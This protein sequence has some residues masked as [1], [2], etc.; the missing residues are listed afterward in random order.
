MNARMDKLHDNEQGNYRPVR[1]RRPQPDDNWPYGRYPDEGDDPQYGIKSPKFHRHLFIRRDQVFFDLDS[2]IGM[3]AMS[4]RKEDGTEDD[5]L[6]NATTTYRQ[7]FCR[8]M[9]KYLGSAKSVM[10]AFVLEKFKTTDMNAV[11]DKD[12]V[13]I[14]L[15]MPE[16]Y[17]DTV[18]EQLTQ[19]VHD[20]IVNGT[21]YEFFSLVL[22]SKD[23]VA[24]DKRE[25]MEEAKG[26]VRKYV[27]AAKPGRIHKRFSPF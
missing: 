11:K 6:T 4:R 14:E 27:Q 20:Y 9:D 13:D 19:A 12:E 17:D 26:E 8:W 15:L 18:F 7:Q 2:Q 24:V 10:S 21:L 22:T 16:W 5:R 23:P 3:L 1:F 25:Q